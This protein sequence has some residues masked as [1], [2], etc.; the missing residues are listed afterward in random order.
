MP[1]T[2][3]EDEKAAE[4]QAHHLAY[5]ELQTVQTANGA[6]GALCASR[7]TQRSCRLTHVNEGSS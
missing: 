5:I 6:E 2:R 1:K 4:D 7:V 3:T